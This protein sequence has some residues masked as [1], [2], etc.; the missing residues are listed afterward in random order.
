M[1]VWSDPLNLEKTGSL[2][3]AVTLHVI[4]PLALV[5]I[6]SAGSWVFFTRQAPKVIAMPAS[7]AEPGI[8]LATEQQVFKEVLLAVLA[9]AGLALTLYLSLLGIGAYRV[10]SRQI[11]IDVLKRTEERLDRAQAYSKVDNGFLYW[12][13]YLES[14]KQ[15]SP[16]ASLLGSAIDETRI[17]Y[18]NFAAGLPEDQRGVSKLV[19]TIRNNWAYYILE[20]HA[21]FK[22]AGDAEKDLARG[23]ATYV[24]AKQMDF[25]EIANDLAD[26]A[27]SVEEGLRPDD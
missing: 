14:K 27:K 10:L 7:D 12:Q 9:V 17:A 26:T 4:L 5:A 15:G 18:V 22:A 3:R 19:T 25:P 11:E 23:F 16:D 1:G 6:L 2:I 13:L 21:T 20:K 8:E 24:R